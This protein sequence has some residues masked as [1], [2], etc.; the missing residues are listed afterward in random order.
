MQEDPQGT[1]P[2]LRQNAH[3]LREISEDYDVQSLTPR[4][5]VELSLDLYSA[6]FLDSHQYWG[7]AFQA[8]LMPNHDATLGALTENKAAPYHPRD[9]I[10]IWRDRLI[11]ERTYPADDPRPAKRT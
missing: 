11:F 10:V 3:S 1:K 5:V 8:E 7:L 2:E 6:G 9:F 4:Q